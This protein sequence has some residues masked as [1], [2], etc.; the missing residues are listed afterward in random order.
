MTAKTG[1]TV[2]AFL[3]AAGVHDAARISAIRTAPVRAAPKPSR[4]AKAGAK[5]KAATVK[6]VLKRSALVS[7]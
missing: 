3:A 4:L 6:P 7:Y 5:I 2:G 1:A